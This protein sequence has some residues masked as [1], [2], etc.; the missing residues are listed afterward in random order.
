MIITVPK[1]G[2]GVFPDGV[3]PDTDADWWQKV[4]EYETEFVI[5]IKDEVVDNSTTS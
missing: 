4:E 1:V 3:L 5:E 2:S